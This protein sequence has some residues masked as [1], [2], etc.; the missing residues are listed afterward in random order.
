MRWNWQQPDWPDFTYDPGALEALERRFLLASGEVTG[1]L[2]HV[3]DAG[4]ALLRIELISEEAIKTS[5]IEGE[6]LDRASVQSSLRRAFGLDAE[7]GP[8]RPGERGIAE[9]MADL[10]R[11]YAS[12][13]T[14]EALHRWHGMIMAGARRIETIGAYRI[15]ADRMQIVSGNLAE[16]RVHFEAPPSEKVPAKMSRFV[17]W[18]NATAPD[19]GKPLPALA[20]AGI[21]HL[22]FESIHPF[23]DGNGR[24]GRAVSEKSLAQSLGRPTLIAL[25]HQI[26]RRRTAYYDALERANKTNAVTDWLVYFGETVLAAQQTTLERIAFHIAKTRLYD[27]YAT[28]F[29][30]R[31]QKAV[32]RMLREG[33]D[34]F[35]GGLSAENYIAITRA[36]RATTTR[37][38]SELVRMGALRRS[39]ERR[40]TRYFLNLD[41]VSPAPPAAGAG[42]GG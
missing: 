19:A 25:A 7:A 41:A 2:R 8:A 11:T 12:P 24:I 27:R 38:L 1:A 26:E 14:H 37:D 23:E 36:S 13:L 22:F 35:K 17:D 29:N 30:A 39:G 3:G 28:R 20:R 18:F 40:H 16:P 21:A 33:P 32:A 31:Q 9:M 6:M 15:H 5:A 42:P 34:G 4:R 10:V